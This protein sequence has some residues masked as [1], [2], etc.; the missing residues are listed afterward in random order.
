MQRE[1][2]IKGVVVRRARWRPLLIEKLLHFETQSTQGWTHADTLTVLENTFI[3]IIVLVP[4]YPF[5][6]T[7][8]TQL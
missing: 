7:F 6:A 3:I 2:A 5:Y 4:E 8:S 1:E